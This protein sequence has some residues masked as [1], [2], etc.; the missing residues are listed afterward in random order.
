LFNYFT[1]GNS[2][3]LKSFINEIKPAHSERHANAPALKGFAAMSIE[4]RGRSV[5]VISS[6]AHIAV[7]IAQ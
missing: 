2:T 4:C 7:K 1:A 3:K 5:W 6:V